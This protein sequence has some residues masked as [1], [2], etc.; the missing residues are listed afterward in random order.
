MTNIYSL[1]LVDKYTEDQYIMAVSQ[2][3]TVL[4]NI[5]DNL[6]PSYNDCNFIINENT[7]VYKLYQKGD[8][9]YLLSCKNFNINTLYGFNKIT[10]NNV[11]NV[12]IDISNVEEYNS[13]VKLNMFKNDVSSKPIL[14]D[15][16]YEEGIMNA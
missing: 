7:S 15:T 2:N 14:F 9:K 4:E 1:V 11:S 8:T 10:Q 12:L 5:L 16:L 6:K 3:K 13:M